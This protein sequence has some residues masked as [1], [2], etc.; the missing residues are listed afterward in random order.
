LLAQFSQ[1]NN[2][3]AREL[4]RRFVDERIDC[5]IGKL[6]TKLVGQIILGGKGFVSEIQAILDEKRDTKEIPKIQRYPGRL[7]LAELFSVR[8]GKCTWMAR[9]R[10][11]F[12]LW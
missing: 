1:E 12:L 8:A 5:Q 4:Y 6:W 11:P 7:P 9:Q 10:D 2:T 3:T